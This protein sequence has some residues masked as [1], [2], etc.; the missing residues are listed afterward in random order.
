MEHAEQF[1]DRT[2]PTLD[3]RIWV[4]NNKVLYSFYQKPVANKC[5][6]HKDSALGMNTK[7]ASHTQNLIRR[8]KNTSEEVSMEKRLAVIN[9]F[10]RQ[11]TMSGWG[12]RRG[13]ADRIR[14]H[15]KKSSRK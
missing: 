8:M 15:E 9:E 11:L 6:I 10:D 14:E 3:F 12:A 1:E 5:V 2:L 13:R 7:I 4:E